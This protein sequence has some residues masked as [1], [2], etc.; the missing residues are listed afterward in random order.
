MKKFIIASFFGCGAAASQDG[1]VHEAF[2]QFIK[3]FDKS[4]SDLEKAER[5][6]IFAKNFQYIQ[7]ENAKGNSFELGITKFADLTSEEFSNHLGYVPSGKAFEGLPYLGRHEASGAELPTSVDWTKE[8]AVTPVKNQ[9]QC[10]SCWSFSTTGAL[11]GALKIATGKLV[12][13]SEQQF[14][15]CAGGSFGNMGCKGGSMDEAFKY[16][17]QFGICTEES[18]AYIAKDGSCHATSCQV[19]LPKGSVVGFKDVAHDEQSLMEAVAKGPVSVAIEANLPSFQLY[20]GGIMGGVCGAQL[21]HGVL[22]VGYGEEDGQ[23]YWFVKNS[24]GPAWGVNG[25]IKLLKGKSGDGECGIRK[26][27]SYPVLKATETINV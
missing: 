5:F 25:Y 22:I 18:Y 4:Y 7:E 13:L 20:K 9:G 26:D 23:K 10:G 14:V 16:A 3:D 6:G 2:E 11:E 19:G 8:G 15:D 12:S 21:D 24:W 27:A 17:E 1:G